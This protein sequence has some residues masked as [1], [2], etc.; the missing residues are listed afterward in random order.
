MPIV[1]LEKAFDYANLKIIFII[2]ENVVIDNK[3]INILY[4]QFSESTKPKLI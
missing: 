3:D 1:D 2:M 4:L